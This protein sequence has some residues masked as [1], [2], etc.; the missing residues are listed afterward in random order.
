MVAKIVALMTDDYLFL[1][2]CLTVIS[3][4]FRDFPILLGITEVRPKEADRSLTKQ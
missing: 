1:R 4:F 3:F 2:E